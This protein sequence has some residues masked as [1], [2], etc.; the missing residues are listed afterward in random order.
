MSV[1]PYALCPCGSGK[2]LKFC[3]SDLVA[4]IERIHRM[5]EGDQPRA[6]LRHVEQTLA[7]HPGRASLLDLKASLELS[8][9]ETDAA[10]KTV[11]GFVKLHPESPTAHACEALLLAE[12]GDAREAIG[13]LQKALALVERDMPLRVY[14]AMGAVGA[15]LLESGHVLAA[16]AHLWLHAALA[17][18]EDTR[19]RE[20]LAALHHYSG[21]PLLL[22]DQ[23]TL[24]S[25]PE[26]AP[27]K[28]EAEQAARLADNGKWQQA[29]ALVDKLGHKYGAEPILLY[30]R[31]VLAGW[32]A[33]DRALVAGLHAYAQLDVPLDD[34]VEAEAVAQ[35]LDP[36]LK[37][38][39]LDSVV[40]AYAI[41]D[42][43]SLVARLTSDR[44]VQS[45]E[46]DPA[47]F[48]NDQPRPR[49]TF[50][51]LDRPMPE[52]GEG[53]QREKVPRMAGLIAVYG[54]QTDR[55]ERLELSIDKGPAFDAAIASLTEIG[56]DALGH[57]TEERVIGA[58]SPVD[59][60]L[61]WRWQLPRDTAPDVRRR[62][63]EEERGVAIV[64]RWPTL[65]LAAL[66]GKSAREAAV[67]PS[68][69]IPLMAAIL[70]LEHGA[71]T[72]RDAD[73]IAELRKE[74]GLPQPE[75]IAAGSQ[76]A[77]TLPLVRVQRI[78]VGTLSDDDLV[79]LYHRSIMV[80]AQTAIARLAQEAVRRPSLAGR[81]PP[82]DAFRRLVA[83]EREPDRALALIDKARSHAKSAGESTAPWDLAEL[84]LHIAAGN[85][86]EAKQSLARIEREHRNDPEVAAALY[87]LLYATGVIPNEMAG[88]MPAEDEM[89]MEAVGAPETAA[90]RIWTPDSDRP[91]GGKSALWTPS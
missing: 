18:K 61:N 24:R 65:P 28:G 27:W 82:S 52:S 49:H 4:E 23:I 71:N 50:V 38:A 85:P 90:G 26:G 68:L 20:V 58:V 17:P 91:S 57:V 59:Q 53:L 77:Q 67:D 39:R 3:C 36:D 31:A 9:E 79:Q 55:P 86:E 45:F 80:G 7:T 5:I 48:A 87:R 19:S 40:E 81:I 34:A 37:E 47:L 25:A 66:G 70:I 42:M 78:D 14:E 35:L 76:P 51:L 6:A 54:R 21:L 29:V 22:R 30:N 46:M 83:A 73:S 88:G 15:A 56:G 43:D 41:T 8:L 84:E 33:D 1:D 12:S 16:Q 72:D 11:E 44:R 60:T 75:P 13:S 89:P 10:R 2:K 74:L 32:L 63:V 69:R 64:E 62:L